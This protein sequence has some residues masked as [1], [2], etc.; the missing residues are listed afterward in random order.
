M[1]MFCRGGSREN[2]EAWLH[3]SWYLALLW[4]L[5]GVTEMFLSKRSSRTTDAPL[6]EWFLMIFALTV[7]VFVPPCIAAPWF[8][9]FCWDWCRPGGWTSEYELFHTCIKHLFVQHTLTASHTG[10]PT[11][12]KVVVDDRKTIK[13][14]KLFK[15][16]DSKLWFA[17]MFLD[18]NMYKM[19][20]YT[21][22]SPFKPN[23]INSSLSTS[24]EGRSQR[25]LDE[26]SNTSLW[27]KDDLFF[28]LWPFWQHT[29][30]ITWPAGFIFKE[31]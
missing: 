11:V 23:L 1:R 4:A 28:I 8:W 22:I 3:S 24:G 13:R 21:D 27:P 18:R 20:V 14:I 25:H 6:V 9:C 12:L 29:D 2:P 10:K 16:K 7:T 31:L 17:V 15:S 30:M 19:Y 26:N 5:A